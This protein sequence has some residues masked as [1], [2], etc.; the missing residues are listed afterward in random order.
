MLRFGYNICNLR[1]QLRDILQ[2]F[3]CMSYEHIEA[4]SKCMN[5]AYSFTEICS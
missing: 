4:E 1:G 3:E 5:F 2:L